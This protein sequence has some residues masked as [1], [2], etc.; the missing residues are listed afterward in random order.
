MRTAT[1]R[2]ENY[3]GIK[4]HCWISSYNAFKQSTV[5]RSQGKLFRQRSQI[6][7]TIVCPIITSNTTRAVLFSYKIVYILEERYFVC[8]HKFLVIFT[9]SVVYVTK[10]LTGTY[11]DFNNNNLI[12]NKCDLNANIRKR[13]FRKNVRNEIYV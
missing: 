6:P 7:K 2:M 5:G 9:N 11:P 8:C 13:V 10:L 12:I 1:G 4:C 3:N